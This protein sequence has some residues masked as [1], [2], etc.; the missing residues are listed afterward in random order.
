[1]TLA[2][3]RIGIIGAGFSGL[4]AGI[5]LKEH[6]NDNF[7]IFEKGDRVG[8]TWRENTYPGAECDIPSALYSYS[9][10]RNPNWTHKWSEQPEILNYLEHCAEKYGLGP[11]FR[12]GEAVASVSF[13]EARGVWTLI[14]AKGENHEFDAIICAVGQLHKA[15]FPN[16][17]GRESFSGPN[18]H[19][20]E[21][22]HSVDLAGKN[23]AVIGNAASAIQFIPQLQPHV[24]TLNV[25]QRSASWM[26]PKNDR[27][28]TPFE[29]WLGSVLPLTLKFYRF[30]IW[31][32]GD[33]QLFS[34]MKRDCPKWLRKKAEEQAI[35]YMEEHV[36]DPAK[37]AALTPDY[38][39]GAKRILFSDDYMPAIG[40]DNVN[41][42]TDPIARITPNSLVTESGETVPADVIVYATGFNTTDF[43]TPMTVTGRAGRVLNDEWRETGAEAYLGITHTGYPNFFMM[44]G[45]NT[46]LG[47][48]SIVL[49]IEAQTR[50]ILSCLKALKD[51]NA[52]WLD[53]HADAQ[54]AYNEWLQARMCDMIWGV[55][56]HSWYMRQ[57]KVTNNW[58]GRTSEYIKRTRK[59]E[60]D[61][62]EFGGNATA[63]S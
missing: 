12:F 32:R 6:G 42:I 10:E 24:K 11:H 17:E 41:L 31:S 62:Y 4:C 54:R 47:H 45:P 9:F 35:A 22:D 48:N 43:V 44:Y 30:L 18:F 51:H 15:Q 50:Y 33:W 39:M 16:I 5:K 14:T 34:L 40:Q 59:I 29:K 25:F 52:R 21:W 1:M 23:V 19:S 60:A 61:K 36:A 55:V 56:D 27:E 20:A 37:R 53:V 63:Q 57:G 7:T 26:L 2:T 46:N 8:G 58:V 49:M 3:P 13:D 38:P 28:Y